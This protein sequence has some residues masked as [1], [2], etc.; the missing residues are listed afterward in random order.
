MSGSQHTSD[1]GYKVGLRQLGFALNIHDGPLSVFLAAN[2][3]DIYSPITV[4]LMNGAGEPLGKREVNLL[5]SVPCMPTLQAMRWALAKHPMLQERLFLLM[6][7]LAHSELL[8]TSGVIGKTEYSHR[9]AEPDREDD[10]AWTGETGIAEIPRSALKPLE[11]QGRGLTHC[12]EKVISAPRT[13]AARLKQLVAAIATEHG[14]DELTKW[15]Q[16][17]RGAV[18]RAACTLLYDSA[19]FHGPNSVSHF[20]QEDAH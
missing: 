12:H 1:A 8:C 18:L 5:H 16:Q 13:R 17:A 11:A 19:V 10:F 15:C 7:E 6:D 20:G 3:A 4:T 2:F 9:D 14:E